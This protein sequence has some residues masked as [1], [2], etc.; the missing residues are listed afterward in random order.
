MKMFSC[1]SVRENKKKTSN[2]FI[3]SSF[4]LC[5][6]IGCLFMQ[7]SILVRAESNTQTQ[8]RYKTKEY[9][10]SDTKLSSP[11]IYYSTE[12]THEEKSF[13]T[14]PYNDWEKHKSTYKSQ[15]CIHNTYTCYEYVHVDKSFVRYCYISTESVGMYKHYAVFDTNSAL[16]FPSKV[17][18]GDYVTIGELEY[19]R[20]STTS[21]STVMI[22]YCTGKEYYRYY[23]WSSWS[24]WSTTPVTPSNSINVQTREGYTI[25]FNGDNYLGTKEILLTH[26][27]DVNFPVPPDGYVYSF[28][29]DGEL[30][31]GKN[32]SENANILVVVEKIT[33]LCNVNE[34]LSSAEYT[35]NNTDKTIDVKIPNNAETYTL[36]IKVSDGAIWGLYATENSTIPL[37]NTFTLK[38]ARTIVRYIKVTSQDN[39]ASKVYKISLYRNTISTPPTFN[40]KR[41]LVTLTADSGEIFYTILTNDV[42]EEN[43]VR[44]T[45][46]FHAPSE[47]LI[48]AY[49]KQADKD[50]NSNVVTILVPKYVTSVLSE[51]EF[52]D[53]NDGSYDFGYVIQSSGEISGNFIIALYN[54]FNKFIGCK[55]KPVSVNKEAYV[56]DSISVNENAHSYKAYFWSD[57]NSLQS[58]SDSIENTIN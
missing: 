55:I 26:G 11:W 12:S 4:I 23:K 48:K 39:E 42:T 7:S 35:I 34:I 45:E 18:P 20:T 5:F 28:Y 50:E 16:V 2:I 25:T 29:K 30:W 9:I 27:E 38:E 49:A 22:E 47:A 44:Y 53:N 54:D 33:S 56:F 13:R 37:D 57:L 52:F 36:N 46:P 19:H 3:K 43:Y 8:Y 40:I 1:C 6:I 17:G 41:D 58:L 24:D 32:V 14:F 10:N 51:I 21:P 31:D 15:Y